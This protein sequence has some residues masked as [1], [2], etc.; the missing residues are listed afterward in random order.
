VKREEKVVPLLYLSP[1][2][3]PF[4]AH[5]LTPGLS[6][7][8]HIHASP[9]ISVPPSIRA[10]A[11]TVTCFRSILAAVRQADEHPQVRG[12]RC[13]TRTPHHVD[14]C[15]GPSPRER[16]PPPRCDATILTDCDRHRGA[17]IGKKRMDVR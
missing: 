4:F 11:G 14:G 3:F 15:G 7:S 13:G 16:F 8:S 2:L 17:T 10:T 6:L 5:F 9:P 1:S 12:A